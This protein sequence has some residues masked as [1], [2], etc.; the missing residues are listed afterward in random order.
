MIQGGDFLRND[1]TGSFSVY[2]AQFED[3]NFNIKHTGPGL[4]SMVSTP[5]GALSKKLCY[6]RTE[7]RADASWLYRRILDLGPM[8]VK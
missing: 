7:G 1:G 5:P 2:G 3:E 8:D 6:K 4:L